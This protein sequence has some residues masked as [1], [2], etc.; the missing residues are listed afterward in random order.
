MKL[1][2]I[3]LGTVRGGLEEYMLKIATVAVNKNWDVHVAFPCTEGT[4]SLIQEF[5]NKEVNYHRLGKDPHYSNRFRKIRGLVN[6]LQTI[7]LLLRIKPDVVQILPSLTTFCFENIIA[8]GLLRVPTLVRFGLVLDKY[9]QQFSSK[10]IKAY[11]WARSR[12]Q[13]WMAVSDNNRKLICD[14]FHIPH[15]EVL[16]IYNGVKL[17]ANSIDSEPKEI[18]LSQHNVRQELGLSASTQLLLTVARLSNQKGYSDLIPTIPHIVK[19][20]PEARFVWVGEGKRRDDLVSKVREYSVQDQ[21]FFLGHRFDVPSLLKSADLFI[22]PTHF[23]GHSTA[24]LEA[25]TYGLK[26]VASD[27]SS[28]PETIEHKVDGLL[29]RTGDSCD[30]LETIRWALRHPEEMQEMAENAKLRVQ[31]F[32]EEKMVKETFGI[33]EKLVKTG[34]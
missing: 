10:R 13:Q 21:V 4:T 17:L 6:F 18:T 9:R 3:S 5:L 2:I 30:L 11:A 24:L 7:F 34:Q 12:N 20:F 15:Q 16:C 26:I 23:E 19:E 1:L 8:C 22:F 33:L 32:S 25:M 29:F 14:S 31:D 28:I 27:A